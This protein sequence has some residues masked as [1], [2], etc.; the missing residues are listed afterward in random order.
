ME[1][2]MLKKLKRCLIVIFIVAHIILGY[3][4]TIYLVGNRNIQLDVCTYT[5]DQRQWVIEHLVA[6][7]KTTK[8]ISKPNSYWRHLLEDEL[9][10]HFYIFLYNDEFPITTAGDS[11]IYSR[12][13]RMDVDRRDT[14]FVRTMTHEI[15]HIKLCS[16]NER[17]VC[18]ETF[19]FLYEHDNTMFRYT[20]ISYAINQ[21]DGLWRDNDKYNIEDQIM[22]YFLN[23]QGDNEK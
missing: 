17:Y 12:V 13:I 4:V 8:L 20:A 19:K 9:D 2:L 3:Y 15:M 18:Y 10:F 6:E 22:Y 1:K 23:G 7:R 16:T 14:G 21:L 5:N 11:N